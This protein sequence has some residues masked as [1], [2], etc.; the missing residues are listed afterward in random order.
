MVL[1]PLATTLRLADILSSSLSALH[2]QSNPLDLG[3]V[4]RAAVLVV[5]GL[6][7]HNLRGVSGHARW[8]S[9]RWASRGLSADAGFPSTTASALTTLT[10]GV[11]P[12]QHGIAGYTLRDP[13]SGVLINHLKSW[14]PH[15]DPDT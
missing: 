1:V 7:A 6:G 8:L 15:V 5:D 12:G 14:R 10:T 2:G 11:E 13:D 9:A 4:K 3:P